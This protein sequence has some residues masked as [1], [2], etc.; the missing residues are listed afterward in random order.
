MM[1][2]RKLSASSVGRLIAA[3]FTENAP[4]PAHDF[5]LSAD[6]VADSGGRLTSYYTAR[7]SRA[8]WRPDMTEAVAKVLG[9]DRHHMPKADDLAR[10]F[11]A[12]R[13]DTGEAWSE[14]KRTVSAYDLTLAPHKSVTLAAEFAQTAAE[15]AMI[16]H[17]VDRANDETM[18]Y[19]AKELGWARKGRGGEDGAEPGQVGWVSFRHHTARPTVEVRDGATG[20]TYLVDS[21]VGGDPH[22]HIHNALFNMVVTEDGHVG[23]LDTQRLHSRVHEFGAYF[24][25]RLADELRRL[26]ASLQYDNN[27]QAVVL[28][29]IPDEAVALFS[30][31]RRQVL[32]SAKDYAEEQGLDWETLTLERKQRILAVTGMASRL[33]KDGSADDRGSWEEQAAAIGWKHKTVL[34]EANHERLSDAE[35][36]EQAYAFAARHL[37]REFQTAA[38]IDHDKLRTYAAR[39]LIG[40]GIGSGAGD[41]TRVTGML[42]SRGV[43]LHGEHVA[44]VIGQSGDKVR[45]TNTAQIRIEE[46]LAA[47]A[48]R[49]ALDKSGALSEDALRA[50]M[51]SSGL[52]LSGEH[53]KAQAAAIYALGTGGGLSLLTGVAGAGKTTLLKPLVSAW[54]ADTRLEEGGRQVIGVAVAWRQAEAL[55]DAGITQTMAMSPFLKSVEKGDFQATRNTVLVIDEISQVAPRQLL[56]LLEAQRETGMTIKVL[57]DREQAQS[58]EAGDVIEIMRRMLPK[59][60]MPELLSTVR[61]ATA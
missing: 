42:E 52:D 45:V 17:A 48:R 36:L 50:A 53:G 40:T 34:N 47:E 56:K 43:E 13:A 16:R 18:R 32:Q 46:S 51:R 7:D 54:Q 14:H 55:R 22:D 11:E 4:D 57:G 6:K 3:Y 44:L 39:G 8:T 26:G 27:E 25:A 29:A 31:G 2:F 10:L 23:S 9:V 12:K 20:V 24:Q 5:R 30:K 49:A 1:T 19:V 58:I 37:A 41:I 28:T 60:E 38:V 33:R 15:S 21:P 59:E 35:R 61:Q